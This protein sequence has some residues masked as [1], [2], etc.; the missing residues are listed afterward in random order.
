MLGE[1][2][3][4]LRVV[5]YF[6]AFILFLILAAFKEIETITALPGLHGSKNLTLHLLQFSTEF[7][8]KGMSLTADYVITLFKFTFSTRNQIALEI[9][10]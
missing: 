8:F 7:S 10:F 9:R 1:S 5:V 6:V 4:I 2:F 3:V